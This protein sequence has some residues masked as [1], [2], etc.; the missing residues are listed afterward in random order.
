[1]IWLTLLND[2]SLNKFIKFYT[3]TGFEPTVQL[4][5]RDCP[6]PVWSLRCTATATKASSATS[7][8]KPKKS[9]SITGISIIASKMETA[10]ISGSNQKYTLSVVQ[11][12][13]R[14]SLYSL[15]SYLSELM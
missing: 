6:Q 13:M 1:M 7:P 2:G 8:A 14:I 3:K 12:T 4:T 5:L 15:S 11:N 10:Y 9:L